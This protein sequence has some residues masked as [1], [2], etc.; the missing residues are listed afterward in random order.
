MSRARHTDRERTS[1]CWRCVSSNT[2][3]YSDMNSHQAEVYGYS[4]LSE[5]GCY[6]TIKKVYDKTKTLVLEDS[7]GENSVTKGWLLINVRDAEYI[8]GDGA[9]SM[10]KTRSCSQGKLE[11]SKHLKQKVV[12]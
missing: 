1:K 11:G 8:E 10:C 5:G 3:F 7:T 12:G 2:K 9:D 6:K 4:D